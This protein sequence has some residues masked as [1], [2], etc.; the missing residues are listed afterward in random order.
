MSE[1]TLSPA[2]DMSLVEEKVSFKTCAPALMNFF[3]P[4]NEVNSLCQVCHC[5][6][7][8]LAWSVIKSEVALCGEEGSSVAAFS[9]LT[10]GFAI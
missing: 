1:W 9:R 10:A 4:S 5:W 2:I 3:F 7:D 8:H 6:T